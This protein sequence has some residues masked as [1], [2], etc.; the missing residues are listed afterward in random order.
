MREV[1][2]VAGT[3][4]PIGFFGG[5]LKDVSGADLAAVVIREVLKRAGIDGSAVDD[6]VFGNIGQTSDAPNVAR[7]GLLKA[8]LPDSIPGYTVNR[9]CGSGLQ[10]VVCGAWAIQLGQADTIVAGGTE[11]MSG[12]PYI[13]K[14]ARWGYRLQHGELTDTLWE[15]LTDPIVKQLMGRTAENLAE[16]YGITRL[17]QDE[18]ALFSHKKANR[19]IAEGKFKEEIVPVEIPSTRGGEPTVFSVDEC[20]KSGLSVEMLSL[21]PTVFKEGGTVTP[22]NS[23]G[24]NDGAA[25]V[26]LMSKEKAQ[27]LGKEPMAFVRSSAVAAVNP[28]YMGIAPAYAIPRA[29][30]RAG[31]KLKDIDLFEV[32]E[33]FAAQYLSVEKELKLDREKVNVNGGAIA[34][35]HPVGASG[36]RLMVTLLYEMRRRQAKL[37][38][39]S[40][41]IGGGQGI[42]MVVERR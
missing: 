24:I 3:R 29:L 13:I 8:G 34:L 28:A 35:G 10:A 21:Y 1:A 7:V 11:N 4:T 31:L 37:G 19:A 41:C 30:D 27:E 33:P 36:T 25:A 32:N 15:G 17:Q 38:V 42:A 6:V 18:Y 12:A 40:L 22:G 5:A 39:V 14:K 16:K 2:I 9:L 23:C 26:V 20:P